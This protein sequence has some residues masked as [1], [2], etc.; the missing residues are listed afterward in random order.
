VFRAPSLAYSTATS[1]RAVATGMSGSISGGH[2]LTLTADRDSN[3]N[4]D[5]SIEQTKERMLPGS[6]RADRRRDRASVR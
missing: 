3:G 1:R 6:L 5:S 2:L 4:S